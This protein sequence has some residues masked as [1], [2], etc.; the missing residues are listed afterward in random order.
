MEMLAAE[1][2]SGRA[3]TGNASALQL[4]DDVVMILHYVQQNITFEIFSDTDDKIFGRQARAL[5]N[6][7]FYFDRFGFGLGR[8]ECW[9]FIYCYSL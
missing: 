9:P 5:R 4:W 6:L 2:K 1:W 8:Q 3:L 7:R